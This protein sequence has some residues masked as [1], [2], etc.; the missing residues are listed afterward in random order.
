MLVRVSP[1]AGGGYWLARVL[2]GHLTYYAVPGNTDAVAT[3]RTQ[4]TRHWYK[5]LRRRQ[6]TRI[7]WTRMNRSRTNGYHPPRET[8]SP[9]HAST[10]PPKAEAQCGSPHAGICVG[11]A[12][13]G[14]PCRDPGLVTYRVRLVAD[15]GTLPFLRL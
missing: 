14:G 11:A 3:F 9:T 6:R 2:R 1:E 10:P 5:A 15:G 7:N 13:K 12:R 8:P 4:T